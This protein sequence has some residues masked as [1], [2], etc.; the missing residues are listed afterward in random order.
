MKYSIFFINKKK[1]L[2]TVAVIV[3]SN[4]VWIFCMTGY[5]SIH[6]ILYFNY[7]FYR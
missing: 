2:K 7:R 6:I 4:T 1:L 5:I 3:S